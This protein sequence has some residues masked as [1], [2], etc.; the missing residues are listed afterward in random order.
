MTAI[1]HLRGQFTFKGA[2]RAVDLSLFGFKN[3]ASAPPPDLHQGCASLPFEQVGQTEE[4]SKQSGSIII[5]EI[6]QARLLDEAA[7]LDELAGAST[8]LD[9]PGAI[10]GACAGGLKAGHGRYRSSL[11]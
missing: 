4:C 2:A 9:G 11:R 8:A 7:Q 5:G 1:G 10:V 3:S 6:D